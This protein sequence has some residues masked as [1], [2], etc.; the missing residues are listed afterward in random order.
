M[1]AFFFR[2]ELH[3]LAISCRKE[4]ACASVQIGVVVCVGLKTQG[5]VGEW[6]FCQVLPAATQHIDTTTQHIGTWPHQDCTRRMAMVDYHSDEDKE[7]SVK[8]GDVRGRHAFCG[9]PCC[10]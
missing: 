9:S 4:I 8:V 10:V 2:V 7:I 3:A 5:D 6:V 1:S